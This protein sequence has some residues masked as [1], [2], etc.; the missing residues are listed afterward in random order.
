VTLE[1][2]IG[3]GPKSHQAEG[4][5]RK[6][7]AVP[8]VPRCCLRC[9]ARLGCDTEFPDD[10]PLPEEHLFCYKVEEKP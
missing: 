1:N 9:S 7:T 8:R 5:K 4:R 6:L 2:G 3:D 10:K